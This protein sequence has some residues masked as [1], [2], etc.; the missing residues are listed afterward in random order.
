MATSIASIAGASIHSAPVVVP[1]YKISSISHHPIGLYRV[2]RTGQEGEAIPIPFQIDELNAYKDFVLT[3]GS[4]NNG[5]TGNGLFDG[6]DEL[7][8]MGNDV[9]PVGAPTKWTPQKPHILYELLF[10]KGEKKGAIYIGIYF[11]SPP[12]LSEQTYVKFDLQ[13]SEV[14]TDRYR[15]RFDHKNHLVVR[16][17]D[18]R[19]PEGEALPLLESS[20]FY[21]KADFKYFL[22]FEV[23]H[24]D[25][26][27]ELE[28]YKIG[29]IRTIV[30]VSFTYRIL[31]LKINLGMYTEVSFFPNAV[32][33]PAVMYNP[34]DGDKSLNTDSGFYYGF[35]AV[36][37]PS[38]VNVQSNMPAYRKARMIDLFRGKQ[39]VEDL[40]WVTAEAPHY[41]LY[42][43]I[44]PSKQMREVRNV[45]MF[46][47]EDK[48]AFSLRKRTANSAK[49]LGESPVNMAIYFDLSRFQP[50]EHTVAF[51]L[52]FENTYSKETLD[53]FKSLAQW[54]LKLMRL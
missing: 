46:Y 1:A 2:F 52:Y 48:P 27:S 50:G 22:T 43:E 32:F 37:D 12:P 53:D 17:V 10:D 3:E 19:K 8:F 49:P 4:M 41:I 34:L 31:R 29:P 18:M 11:N 30:R 13:H 5:K 44:E 14:I 9:G 6:N 33:L 47:K 42:M 45:P 21:L 7:S 23:N 26:E 35:A 16:G 15:Y 36:D 20:T 25:I 38:K 28:A 24:R 40:Y 39:K 54:K 51:R